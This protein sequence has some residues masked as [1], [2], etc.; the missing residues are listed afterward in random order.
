[1]AGACQAQT[2]ACGVVPCVPDCTDNAC[3]D[4]GCG[5]SCGDCEAG[6]VCAAGACVACE[7]VCGS[8]QECGDDGCG[9]S[10]GTCFPGLAC[11]DG[12]CS[13]VAGGF[14]WPC[15]GDAEC[16]STHCLDLGAAKICTVECTDA[17]PNGFACLP[18]PP[19]AEVSVCQ[20]AG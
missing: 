14:G 7:P 13:S 5:G 17:C 19:P 15:T 20:L 16:D 6:L 10:C 3:G 8:E 2:A 12:L 4:D 11:V 18:L 1:M 9:G